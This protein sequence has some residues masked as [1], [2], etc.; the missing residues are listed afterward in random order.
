[1]SEIRGSGLDV[2]F[3]GNPNKDKVDAETA[4]NETAKELY[5]IY[6]AHREAGFSK[7]QSFELVKLS[8]EMFN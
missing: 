6:K 2:L 4:F 5:M 7:K 3:F 1:M 8:I